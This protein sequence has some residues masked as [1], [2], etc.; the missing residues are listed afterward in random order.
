MS[1]GRVSI[2]GEKTGDI[3]FNRLGKLYVWSIV[4][5][6]LLYFIVVSGQST[7]GVGGNWSRFLQFL[8]L[9]CIGV[10]VL[11][12]G[13]IWGF[14]PFE[15]LY[16]RFS[17]YFIFVLFSA[18]FGLIS[19]A[20]VVHHE[21]ISTNASAFAGF[22][23]SSQIRP[24][25]EYFIVIYYFLY[26]VVLPRFLL[27][28]PAGV[29]YFFKIFF[30][31]FYLS[32][33]I[34]VIDLFLIKL[35]DVHLLSRHLGD[36]KYPGFRFH[37]LAGEPRD[38]FVYLVL[39]LVMY[40]LRDIWRDEKSLTNFKIA[41]IFIALLLTQSFSGL[42]AMVFSGALVGFYY[43]PRVS[44]AKVL[45]GLLIIAVLALI[46][47]SAA[48]NSY[49][50]MRYYEAFYGLY[51]QLESGNKVSGLM[52][53]VMNNIYPVWQRWTEVL[54]FN[55]LP[56]LIGTGFGSASAINN[57]FLHLNEIMNPNS[58]LVRLVYGNGIVGLYLFIK[59]FLYPLKK[60]CIEKHQVNKLILGMLLLLGAFFGH[61][62]ACPY[63]FLG[64]IFVVFQVKSRH[65]NIEAGRQW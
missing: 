29:N 61:R 33:V 59:A 58:N 4:F 43:L 7:L 34:G 2:L 52:E 8:V 37:G 49:R 11:L 26:F 3:Q 23:L 18:V 46:A 65:L 44:F 48:Q 21:S 27:A 55:F 12:K 9:I 25:F 45:S 15:D 20:Y 56:L 38:A 30:R 57:N 42:F 47:V 39:G 53:V 6:P 17:Y 1:E 10:R 35:A 64:I 54:E 36:E 28:S 22:L 13:S 40:L 19:G 63:I 41:I 51:E 50:I 5:E 32:F 16:K 24:F 31:V 60:V 14:N 62:S